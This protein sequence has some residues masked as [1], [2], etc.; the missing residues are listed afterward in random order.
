MR[1]PGLASGMDIDSMVKDMLVKENEKIDKAKQEQQVT[2][3]KQEMYK[4]IIKDTKN[5]FDKYLSITSPNSILSS[6][7]FTNVGIVSSNPNIITATAGPGAQKV[8]YGFQI[9][10]MA[11]PPQLNVGF[12]KEYTVTDE[13]GNEVT[14]QVNKSTKLEDIF[15]GII[16]ENDKVEDGKPVLD[17]DGNPIKEGKKIE[18]I[19][20][21]SDG[22][23][24]TTTIEISSGETISSLAD[25]INKSF[26]DGEIKASFSEM[27]GEFTISGN[28]TGENSS[29]TVGGDLLEHMAAVTPE[30]LKSNIP[31][32]GELKGSNLTGSVLDAEGKVI[33]NLNESKNTFTI[34]NITYD[35]HGTS[36]SS[37]DESGNKVYETTSMTGVT[38]TTKAVENMAA[39]INDYN[40]LMD[41]I[42]SKITEKKPSDFKPL[43][44][45]QKS[46][47]SK[48]EI[49]KWEEKAKQG[50]LRND[51][52]L[53]SF[54]DEIQGAIFGSLGNAGI[55]LHEMG[56]T[57]TSDYNKKNQIE[58]DP[59]KFAKALS[60]R[61]DEVYD[62]LASTENGVFE[63]L[64]DIVHKY[65]GSSA[66]IFGQKA[67]IGGSSENNN[68]Y[69]KEIQKKESQI[70]ELTKKM[71]AKEEALYAKFAA[72]ESS[73]NKYNS[74][75][76]YFMQSMGY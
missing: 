74:Q 45:E 53:R 11:K 19:T 48:E 51:R 43:T 5:L 34:D 71:K 66:S 44:E 59:D 39:F 33:K 37:I 20:K 21:D 14:K 40:K 18:I 70:K 22:K 27:T 62:A 12:P 41:G 15:P 8:N 7:N 35:I 25:K 42:Y 47:M 24:K 3:W 61:G 57:S 75:M 31:Q 63:K 72:L 76:S 29:F 30:P 46:E 58:F 16:T 10:S 64:K 36:K 68:V 56:I 28:E 6:K 50:I 1:I 4:D 69:S 49:A 54:M 60:E 26:P 32:N 38:D 13:D 2:K 65:S 73:L 67:G 17:K 23:D 55:S 9:E 52:E